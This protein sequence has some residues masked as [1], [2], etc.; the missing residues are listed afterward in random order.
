MT[1]LDE[2]LEHVGVKGMRWGVRKSRRSGG[3]SSSDYSTVRKLK[4]KKISELSN[5]EL[6]KI[7]SRLELE[8]RVSS[9]DSSTTTQGKKLATRLLGQYGNTVATALIGA[10]STATVALILRKG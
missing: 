3:K 8:R 10:A 4:K 6:S 1:K 5:K 9:L 2:I 7:T